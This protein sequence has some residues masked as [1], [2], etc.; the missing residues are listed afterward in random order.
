MFEV[1]VEKK[2]DQL[3]IKWKF[4]KI[5]VPLLEIMEV[6]YDNTYA[7]ENKSAM[8][9]GYPYGTTDRILIR[10]VHQNYIIYTNIGG[11]KERILSFLTTSVDAR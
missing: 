10:T 1:K 3:V 2:H 4:S 11:T 9:I 5:K 8:R 6:S 7:G